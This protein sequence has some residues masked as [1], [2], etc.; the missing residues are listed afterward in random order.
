MYIYVYIYTNMYKDIF[1][2]IVYNSLKNLIFISG[3]FDEPIKYFSDV[4]SL[5]SANHTNYP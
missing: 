5:N 4:S 1:K 2:Y 3:D